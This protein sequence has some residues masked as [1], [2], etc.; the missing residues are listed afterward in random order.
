M[1]ISQSGGPLQFIM[2]WLTRN[3]RKFD[4]FRHPYDFSGAFTPPLSDS[5][6]LI[7]PRVLR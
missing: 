2:V 5:F 6:L 1:P 3:L 7:N 4:L